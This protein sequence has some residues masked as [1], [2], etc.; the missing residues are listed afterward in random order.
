VNSRAGVAPSIDAESVVRVL[1]EIADISSETL[2]LQAIFDRVATS[3]RSIIPFED[4]GVVRIVDDERAVL[5]A[6]TVPIGA[7]AFVATE[8]IPLT[9]WSPRMRPRPGP[10]PRVEDARL[11]YD[12]TFPID[13]N[14]L[15]WG[16]L[17]SVWEPFRSTESLRGGVWLA[18]SRPHAFTDEHQTVPDPSRPSWARHGTG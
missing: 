9:A 7:R 17:S 10:I 1:S 14:T 3:V 15:A 16:V 13:A 2:Q 5:H 18:A 4:M 11:E 12:P 8:P 6:T